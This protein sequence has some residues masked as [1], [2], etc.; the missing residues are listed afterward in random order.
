M[1]TV[2]TYGTFD[3]FHIGHLELINRIK[4]LGDKVIIAVSTDE[5]NLLKNK[6]CVI[7]YEQR[8]AIVN[9]IKGVDLVIPENSW[10]Q[11]E[12]DILEH[13]VDL[14]V[15]GDDWTGHFDHLKAVCEVF[16]LPRTEGVS[17]TEIKD[18][19][20]GIGPDLKQEIDNMFSILESIKKE[21][22]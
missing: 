7:P 1:R 19:L 22:Q 3:M 8:A 12:H 14:F 9:A 18:L 5:F 16:Y 21:L 11:K 13:A 20:K 15:M 6:K 2:I 17:T 4:D 10:E